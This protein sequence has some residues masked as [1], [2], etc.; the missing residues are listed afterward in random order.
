[1]VRQTAKV[2]EVYPPAGYPHWNYLLLYK[3]PLTHVL[4]AL[5]EAA[6]EVIVVTAYAPD[7]AKWLENWE[8][9]RPK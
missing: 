8:T 6:K 4:V 1:M 9:R 2:I 5:D 7:P 3:E